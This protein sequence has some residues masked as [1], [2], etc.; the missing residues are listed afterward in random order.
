[1]TVTTLSDLTHTF[2]P[3]ATN[4]TGANGLNR[5]NWLISPREISVFHMACTQGSIISG[6]S[7][8]ADGSFVLKAKLAAAG[9]GRGVRR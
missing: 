3:I 6:Q 5:W 4:A 9:N 8:N 7:R 1:M 2:Q